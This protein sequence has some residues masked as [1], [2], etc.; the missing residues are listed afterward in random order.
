MPIDA[1]QPLRIAQVTSQPGTRE[2]GWLPIGEDWRRRDE[3]VPWVLLHGSRPGPVVYVQA[4]SDGDELNG[5]AV[6]RRLIAE[7]DPQRLS[8]AVLVVP[9]AN[10]GAFAAR[11]GSDPRDGRKLNR[12][13]P[14]NAEGSV[15][16]R[17]AH[18]LFAHLVLRS[19]LVIDLHQNGSIP[20]IPEVRVRTGRRGS[21]ARSCGI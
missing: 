4:V 5:L 9:V 6:A 15:T 11:Q 16:E 13:F 1:V 17:L 10:P 8:G 7:I 21:T 2:H 14:G 12:C 20:M 19:D 18:A 3:A